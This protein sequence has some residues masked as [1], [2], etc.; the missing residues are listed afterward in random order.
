MT[1][2]LD[3]LFLVNFVLDYCILSLTDVLANRQTKK[4]RILLG[5]ALGG[6]GGV[7]IFVARLS[8]IPSVLGLILS[9]GMLFLGFGRPKTLRQFCH[10][11]GLFYGVAFFMGSILFALLFTTKIGFSTQA[12][13]HNGVFYA[14]LSTRSLLLL[15]AFADLLLRLLTK[16]FKR[17]LSRLSHYATLTFSYQQ[18]TICCQA[19]IDTG[20][21]LF[22]PLY[23]TPALILELDAAS[24]LFSQEEMALL[25]Q[26]GDLSTQAAAKFHPITFH[27][28]GCKEGF[29]WALSPQDIT[30]LVNHTPYLKKASVA[31]YPSH[32]SKTDAYQALLSP[33]LILS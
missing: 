9:T 33:Q 19:L 4:W 14:R 16:L 3:T 1:I 6:V 27:S 17:K 25:K 11:S 18:K 7:G 29:L 31:L 30:V 23:Q 20:N 8:K 24:I 15:L 32:L 12:A 5:G 28:L 26:Q 2:Y 21:S 13:F 22:D 10:T